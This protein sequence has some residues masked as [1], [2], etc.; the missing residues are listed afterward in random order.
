MSSAPF[1]IH[2]GHATDAAVQRTPPRADQRPS[3]PETI[4]E[5]HTGWQPVDLRELWAERELLYFLVWRDLK[6]QYKQTVLGPVWAILRPLMTVAVYS[7]LFGRL[8]KIPSGGVP[9]PLFVFAGL[10]P[11]MFFASAVSQAG[12][13]LIGNAHLVTKL[14]FPR[15]YVPAAAVGAALGQ[16]VVNGVIYAGLMLW[17]RQPPGPSV[18]LL[19]VLIALTVVT[20]LGVGCVMASVAVVYRD[21]RFILTSLIQAW[22]FASPVIYPMTLIPENYRWLMHLN[23]MTGVIGGFR[24]VL[25]NQPV[26][27]ASLGLS[28]L[29]AIAILIVGLVVFRRAERRFADIA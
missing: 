28:A 14:Y 18:I 5:P 10:M 21:V 9:Y 11:W 25:L 2:P 19:P 15:L 7:I 4:I 16:F 29:I 3:L 8:A 1:P 12:V 6:V 26:H 22:M 17:Y 13:S 23:P 27:W 20:A 24:S